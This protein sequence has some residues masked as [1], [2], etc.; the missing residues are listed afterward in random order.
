MISDADKQTL[1]TWAKKFNARELFLFGSSLEKGSGA[2]DIDIAVRGIA[3]GEFFDFHGKL[4]RH[5]SRPVDVVN[6]A[7][8]SRFTETIEQNGVKI[9]EKSV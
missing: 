7:N 2:N 9:Y 6:L 3:S 8:P 4:L 5:L 1:I